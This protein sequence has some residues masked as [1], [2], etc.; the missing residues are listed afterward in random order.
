MLEQSYNFTIKNGSRGGQD[1]A[2]LYMCFVYNQCVVIFMYTFKELKKYINKPAAYNYKL[3]VLGDTATQLLVQ[4]VKGYGAV[5]DY[6]IDIYESE[7]DQISSEIINPGSE[8]YTFSPQGILLFFSVQTLYNKFCAEDTQNRTSFA[9]KTLELIKDYLSVINLRLNA[10]IF[11]CNFCEYNDNVWGNYGSSYPISF[12]FQLRKLNFLISE[13]A[14]DAKNVFIIDMQDIQNHIGDTIFSEKFYYS[15]KVAISVD[16]L[17]YMAKA[18]FDFIR[19]FD[20]KIKKCAIL[21][22]D[23]T[24]W[25][26]VIGDDGLNNIQIGELGIGQAFSDFQRWLK[27]LGQRG[28]ILAVCSKNNEDTAKEPFLKHPDMI[29]KLE[30]IALFTANWSDKA[31]NIKYIQ[32]VL[33]IGFDSMVFIDDNPFERELV[34]SMLPEITV[35]DIPDDPALYK[36]YLIE[37]NYFGTVSVSEEDSI[38]T[39]LYRQEADRALQKSLFDNIEDYLKSLE[40]IGT[41]KSFDSFDIPRIAQLTQ[42]SNQFNL[43]TVRYS[44]DDIIRIANSDKHY[45]LSFHLKDKFGDHGLIGVVILKE[46]EP[47]VLFVDTWLMSC[48]VLKR[49]V[50]EFIVNTMLLCAKDHGY[51]KIIGEYIKTEKNSMVKSIYSDMG[52]CQTSENIFEADVDSFIQNAAFIKI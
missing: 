39:Q 49:T 47:S 3:A 22:L 35:P 44:E 21:D 41:V 29:L 48:R 12:I 32:S 16:A 7:Y 14:F 45:T 26:G 52:F 34:K 51:K 38:R 20:G 8:L 42:R 11:L 6:N 19:C 1:H 4:A 28:I 33:N 37:Q 5:F 9:E 17:P 27:Q 18:I 13:L 23:N 24:L 2:Y 10:K 40:M 46:T 30:D 43:R 50:E 31:S 36:S 25:G 15:A